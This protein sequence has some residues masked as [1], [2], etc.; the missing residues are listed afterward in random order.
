MNSQQHLE[1]IAR[2]LEA[3]Y[4]EGFVYDYFSAFCDVIVSGHSSSP[5]DNPHL[6]SEQPCHSLY[7]LG[8][9]AAEVLLAEL[10]KHSQK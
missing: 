3:K 8:A 5:D 6:A 2:K 7:H 9:V 1:N 10:H 4:G